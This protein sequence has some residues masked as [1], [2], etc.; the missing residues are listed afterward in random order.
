MD[1]RPL[2][3]ETDWRNCRAE[4]EALEPA[5]APNPWATWHHLHLAWRLA[6]PSA[7]CWLVMLNSH[8]GPVAAGIFREEESRRSI[9]TVKTL[10]TL[11]WSTSNLPPLIVTPE[12]AAA[13]Y[14]AL[15]RRA[16]QLHR[17]TGAELFCLHQQTESHADS[18]CM[19]LAE[20]GLPFRRLQTSASQIIETGPFKAE[21]PR[22]K[23][24]NVR[25]NEGKLCDA[26]KTSPVLFRTRG[27][28]YETAAQEGIWDDLDRLWRQSWQNA[29][30]ES[31]E[32]GAG[33]KSFAYFYESL[34][35]WSRR[36]WLDIAALKLGPRV[37][38]IY[39]NLAIEGKVWLL[40]TLYDQQLETYGVGSI[41]LYKMLVDSTARGDRELD[42]GGEAT[43][44]KRRWS[45]T[46]RPVY[47]IEFALG[48]PFGR[49]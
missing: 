22:N 44:W 35:E 25:R 23:S 32:P 15:V 40:L 17:T 18:L 31:L 6:F 3:G 45:T 48:G 27:Q 26:Y 42:F 28:V 11:D 20:A 4:V 8:D 34:K 41:N 16:G 2:N 1:V 37:I 36:Q 29:Y 9:K 49:L 30:L 19:A 21:N 39:I 14:C 12:R 46:E 24:R 13:A 38:A 10:R 33:A 7:K 47:Q 5:V 43:E